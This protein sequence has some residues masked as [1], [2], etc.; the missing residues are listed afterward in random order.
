MSN[1]TGEKEGKGFTL[2]F[3]L[4]AGSGEA[5]FLSCVDK[6][7]EKALEFNPDVVGVSSGF[8]GY[9]KDM[10]I[11][12]NYTLNSYY[13]CGRRL[14]QSFENVF[15]V[16]EGGYHQNIR[17]CVDNFINGVNNK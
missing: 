9:E 12:L 5:E 16:L 3:P 10:L 1:E 7:I 4:P 11:N 2:N 13:E 17:K 6:A 14:S 15:A 8:D